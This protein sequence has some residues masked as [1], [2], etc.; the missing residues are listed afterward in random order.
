M[1]IGEEEEA[2]LSLTYLAWVST[3]LPLGGGE[4]ATCTARA[5][6]GAEADGWAQGA[7][8]VV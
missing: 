3:V 8:R 7:V 1:G 2:G 6:W 5:T 4:I